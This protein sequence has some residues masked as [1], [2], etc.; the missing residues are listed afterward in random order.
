M[1]TTNLN[2]PLQAVMLPS[3]SP[4]EKPKNSCHTDR[5]H[6]DDDFGS[7][8][9]RFTMHNL[10]QS[11]TVLEQLDYSEE[12]DRRHDMGATKLINMTVIGHMELPT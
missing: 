3:G 2:Q 6:Y 7:S 9:V 12:S 5:D 11:G 1:V 4:M 10:S 8:L